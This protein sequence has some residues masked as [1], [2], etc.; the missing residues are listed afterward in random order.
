MTERNNTN[1]HDDVFIMEGT[2]VLQVQSVFFTQRLMTL[3]ATSSYYISTGRFCSDCDRWPPLHSIGAPA[4]VWNQSAA[5]KAYWTISLII[6]V[7]FYISGIFA[8]VQT[9]NSTAMLAN[10]EETKVQRSQNKS[11]NEE[12]SCNESRY[13]AGLEFKCGDIFQYFWLHTAK[14]LLP[15][16]SGCDSFEQMLAFGWVQCDGSAVKWGEERRSSWWSQLSIRS[17]GQKSLRNLPD[18]STAW[19]TYQTGDKLKTKAE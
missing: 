13:F 4:A 2:D 9:A 10:N 19:H 7:F 1:R 17:E 11:S 3:L 12:D 16:L 5:S 14:S 6:D 15:F 18:I 8:F